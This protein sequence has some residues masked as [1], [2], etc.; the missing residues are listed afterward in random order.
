MRATFRKASKMA[1]CEVREGA[2]AGSP[3]ASS[4]TVLY[5]QPDGRLFTPELGCGKLNQSAGVMGG[6]SHQET[7]LPPQALGKKAGQAVAQE[8]SAAHRRQAAP[9]SPLGDHGLSLPSA[10]ES[11]RL[12]PPTALP[13]QCLLHAAASA[14]LSESPPVSSSIL[15][16]TAQ[17]LQCVAQ[18]VAL[19][20][21]TA[22][23]AA[24]APTR[25]LLPKQLETMHLQLQP[26][27]AKENESPALSF[28]SVQSKNVAMAQ[29]VEKNSRVLGLHVI[30]PQIIRIQPITGTGSHQ[31]FFCKSSDPTVQ[32]LLQKPAHSLGQV[33][34]NK[35]TTHRILNEQ[36]NKSVR[37]SAAD[38]S[39]V[40]MGSAHSNSFTNHEKKQ[41]EEKLKKS[42]KVKTRSGRISR[43]PKYKAKDYK[44]IKTEDLAD[45]HKSDSD[46][47]S[48]L[49]VEDDEEGK[50]VPAL[51]GSLNS[52]LRPKLFK[53]QTC[54]KSYIGKGGLARHYKLHPG[55]QQQESS[56]CS[57]INRPH[58]VV[59]LE[60]TGKAYGESI[61]QTSSQT[62]SVTLI[63]ENALAIDLEKQLSTESGQQSTT[64]A[65]DGIFAE[66]QNTQ[67]LHVGPGRPRRPRRRGRPK[68]AERSRYTG[69]FNRPGQFSSK[70]LNNISAEHHSVIKR[71]ARLKELIQQCGNEDFM[72]LA[73][74]HFTALVTVF[75]FLLMKVGKDY[76]ARA[77]FP[78]VYREFEDLHAM[79]KKMCQDY[80]SNPG[81]SEPLQI[82][83]HKVA[84][85]LGITASLLGTQRI[86]ADLSHKCIKTTGEHVFTEMSRQK[87]ASESSNE[88]LLFSKK[89]RVENLLE[90][91]NTDYSSNSE[92]KERSHAS[93]GFTPEESG[94]VNNC[95]R[96]RL[97]EEQPE[98]L[99]L[100]AANY[101]AN[102]DLLCHH[103]DV[104]H[105]SF[106][107]SDHSGSPSS[108]SET[109][110][111]IRTESAE[112]KIVESNSNWNTARRQHESEL[113]YSDVSSQNPDCSMHE[114][115]YNENCKDFLEE[116]NQNFNDDTNSEQ[117]QCS[118]KSL[119]APC[120]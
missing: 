16:N 83:N 27:Q 58:R 101:C 12:V 11:G 46:D 49:I 113:H 75:E 31:F 29:P 67:L 77:V 118:Y 95:S 10:Q 105:E 57:P 15:H 110:P 102:P 76:P 25:L 26:E 21:G 42:L 7:P 74:P 89:A 32:L 109:L 56:Q 87:R 68:M 78:D 88:I 55:H 112:E 52:D 104:A 107:P 60:D 119:L 37:T 22:K 92:T 2:A 91:V 59:L 33:S 98:L 9:D 20:Q 115:I 28:A 41:K 120:L 13:G 103:M 47:Y 84:E 45:S 90:D 6:S 62:T 50:E 97:L 19:Q 72:E 24:V 86:Q 30:N 79:V 53:C 54:E 5:P 64:S 114:K 40:T 3:A 35:I 65:D 70:S 18:R 66:Q 85:S 4:E 82:K 1:A 23:A 44:F 93:E 17:Q 99:K 106:E 43:P 34:L 38:A 39:N 63:N 81:L 51:F 100:E 117:I 61:H 108:W 14:S 80:F 8:G 73:V 116:E 48:E 111:T 71:K 96:N 36:K 94:G 69:R